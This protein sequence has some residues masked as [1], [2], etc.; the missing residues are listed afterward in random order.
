MPPQLRQILD[1]LVRLVVDTTPKVLVALVVIAA[2][3]AVA[4]LVERLLRRLLTRLPLERLL[5]Q[6]GVAQL[7]GRSGVG[8][9][10]ATVIP[11]LVYYLL[12]LL[13]ARVAAD[14]YGLVAISSAIGALFGYL[15]KV[16]AALLLLVVGSTVA[17][18]AREAVTRAAEASGIDFAATLGRLVGAFLLFV[19][20]AMAIGQLEFDTAMVRIVTACVLGGFALAF[21]LA[22]GLG[23]RDVTRS[24]LAGFYAR[25][26]FTPG[27]RVEVRGIRGELQAI[28]PTQTLIGRDGVTVA[29]ANS[30]FLD[31]GSPI[32]RQAAAP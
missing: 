32:E 4:A 23:S 22:I 18:V 13:F 24:I 11:R 10:A 21:A 12:L 8:E 1:E 7:L 30:V 17:K 25:K 9:A 15:P 20:F 27:D 26:L 16:A 2:L 19:A 6:A 14:A 5:E 31:D 29:V 3:V 28:T